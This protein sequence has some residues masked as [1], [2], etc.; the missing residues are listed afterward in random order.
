MAF[1]GAAGG[2]T[3]ARTTQPRT[4]LTPAAYA[5]DRSMLNCRHGHAHQG[6]LCCG[7]V[8][9]LQER[10]LRGAIVGAAVPVH[11]AG[12]QAVGRIAPPRSPWTG[13]DLHR[14]HSC[15]CA[16]PALP[17][18]A[19]RSA[20]PGCPLPSCPAVYARHQ[21][22]AAPA[23]EL[24]ACRWGSRYISSW[25]HHAHA[26]SLTFQAPWHAAGSLLFLPRSMSVM[27]DV[28]SIKIRHTSKSSTF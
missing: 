28:T 3:H 20:A 15:C 5:Q 11:V 16:A 1:C 7:V 10:L 25:R 17:V 9:V 8:V 12:I 19:A 27:H 18:P 13:R 2:R 21:L 14:Q 22:W 4:S 6:R 26:S 24:S 23:A